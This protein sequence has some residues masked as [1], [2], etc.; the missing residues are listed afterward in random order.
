[1]LLSL[2]KIMFFFWEI[3]L[4]YLGVILYD[5]YNIYKTIQNK[6]GKQYDMHFSLDLN[7]IF[8]IGCLFLV[9]NDGFFT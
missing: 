8:G 3:L 2:H 9:T 5:V 6:R 4:K 7:A 1:M